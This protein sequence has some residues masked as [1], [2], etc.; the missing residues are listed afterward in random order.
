MTT[1]LITGSTAGIGA[2]FARRLASD[3]RN[4]VLVARDEKRLREQATELHDL[5]GVEV[6]V[7]RADLA[8]EAGITAVEARLGDRTHPVEVLVNNAGFA[9]R[10]RY[11]QAPLADE[12]RMLKVHCEAVLRLTSAA[13][14]T[15]R[16]RGAAGDQR[17]LGRGV[18]AARYVRGEQGVGRA[19]HAGAAKDLAGSGV[20][21]MALCPGWCARSSTSGPGSRPTTC[22]GSCGSTRT[23][24][25]PPP[26]GLRP[27]QVAVHPRP[28]LQGPDGAGEAGAAV[29]GVGRLHPA[30]TQAPAARRR[31]GRRKGSRKDGRR[32]AV[33]GRA[34]A[35]TPTRVRR[36]PVPRVGHRA[37]AV[38]ADAARKGG[39]DRKVSAS[40]RDRDRRPR[41]PPR[42]ASRPRA[43]RW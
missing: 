37:S 11:L 15:M 22:R 27:G 13:V 9:N 12:L 19:V 3:G 41:A 23:G 34:P 28:A 10:A 36:G 42:R 2:A 4:L 39:A 7:L 38:T 40:G 20:R 35:L 29:R 17:R 30:G 31:R 16:E 14:G 6:E 33:A 8:E 26:L 18:R 1:A 24:W 5:H 25:W 32:G 43:S 21:L